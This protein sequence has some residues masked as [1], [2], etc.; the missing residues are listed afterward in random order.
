M[1][2]RRSKTEVCPFIRRFEQGGAASRRDPGP[3]RRLRCALCLATVSIGTLLTHL[4]QL[5][6]GGE[7]RV[8]WRPAIRPSGLRRRSAVLSCATRQQPPGSGVRLF[9][10]GNH[11][12][13]PSSCLLELAVD[14]FA[15]GLQLLEPHGRSCARGSM[16]QV[17]R[18]V[19]CLLPSGSACFRP[20]RASFVPS[21][22]TPF[23][24]ILACL[25][26]G[27]VCGLEYFVSYTFT[28]LLCRGM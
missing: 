28:P 8:H 21:W 12:F 24:S 19:R 27:L 7:G 2:S 13:Q 23:R 25:A 9:K 11:Y 22:L 16:Q 15:I 3:R 4:D 18:G 5:L 17:W 26:I 6:V 1:A 14:R 10:D 20:S